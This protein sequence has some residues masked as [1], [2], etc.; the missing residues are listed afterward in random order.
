MNILFYMHSPASY[1]F[2]FFLKLRRN[3]KIFVVYEN[4]N[5]DNFNWKFKKYKWIYFLNLIDVEK[6]IKHIIKNKKPDSVIIGGYNMNY[7]NIFQNNKNFKIYYWLERLENKFFFKSL[8][9]KLILLHKLK[10]V[11]GILAIGEDAKK[12][13]KSYNKIVI[14]LPYSINKKNTNV[15][16]KNYDLNF[17]YVGQL[18]KRKGLKILIDAIS[19]ITDPN[20]QFTI[21]GSGPLADKIKSIKNSNFKYHNFIN[22]EKLYKVYDKNSI[23]IVPSIFDGWAVTVIEAMSRGL[24]VIS[25]KNVGSYNEYKKCGISGVEIEMNAQSMIDAIKSYSNYKN[26]IRSHGIN[27]RKIFIKN[28]CNSSLA[29]NKLEKFLKKNK[30]SKN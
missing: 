13:Y 19:K 18:I 12:Y 5:I 7:E 22:K 15:K 3:N 2:D 30:L 8:I 23:L 24:V 20:F 16:K 14:N 25:S 1:H 21:V 17:L 26:K 10:K 6:K 9:R 4:R 29:A 28:L 11:D 27:N